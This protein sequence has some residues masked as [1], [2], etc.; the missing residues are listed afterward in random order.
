MADTTTA[1]EYIDIDPK[2]DV[3]FVCNLTSGPQSTLILREYRIRASSAVL[4]AMSSVFGCMLGP[5]F[6]EGTQLRNNSTVEIALPDD[7]PKAI[8]LLLNVLHLR[9]TAIPD[10]LSSFQLVDVAKLADKY[11]CVEQVGLAARMWF[12]ALEDSTNVYI[13]GNLLTASFHL[14]FAEHFGKSSRALVMSS[15]QAYNLQSGL[16]MYGV[17]Q[18][19][20][21]DFA[22]AFGEYATFRP[23]ENFS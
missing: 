15:K 16:V 1:T 8:I 23:R 2:G 12:K 4:I 20:G 5:H 18:G 9:S 11:L 22:N 10:E 13:Q 17:D 19:Q 14:N 7:E 21:Q 6:K 3:I